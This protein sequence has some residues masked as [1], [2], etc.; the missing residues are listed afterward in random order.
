MPNL[1]QFRAMRPPEKIVPLEGTFD[2]VPSDTTDLPHV[3]REVH[4][5]AGGN[6]TAVWAEG[7]TATRA[8][9]A[10]ERLPW[11]LVRVLATGTTATIHGFY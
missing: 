8:I 5:V 9:A 10:G 6:V 7:M 1:A 3:T 11:A 4:A 2:I